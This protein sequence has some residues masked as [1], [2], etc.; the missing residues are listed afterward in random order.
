VTSG[1]R[2]W[3][4]AGAGLTVLGIAVA[5]TAPIVGT[6][7]SSRTH[8]QQIAGGVL[9]VL[10]WALLAWAIHAFGRARE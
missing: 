1:P 4:A 2:R 5:G 8:A 10:G 6:E 7:G 3:M 9:V